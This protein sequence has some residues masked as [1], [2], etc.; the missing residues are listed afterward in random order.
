MVFIFSLL[1]IALHS[2]LS[3]NSVGDLS[4]KNFLACNSMLIKQGRGVF[5]T[6]VEYLN[7][8]RISKEGCYVGQ[9]VR[10]KGI[11]QFK[12]EEVAMLQE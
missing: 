11:Y 12:V 2:R 10:R 6:I 1:E 8:F 3:N 7:N 4:V 9:V 5:A